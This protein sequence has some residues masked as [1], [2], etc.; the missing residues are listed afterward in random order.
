ML[1]LKKYKNILTII[2]VSLVS[3][4]ILY[5]PFLL[6]LKSVLGLVIHNSSFDYIYRNFDGVLYIVPAKTWYAPKLISA[7]R[8]EV[9]LPAEYYA[10]HL[11]VYPFFIWLFSSV[12]G[13]LKSMI[14][15][16]LLFTVCLALLFYYIVRYFKLSQNAFVLSLV[17]L[18]LPRFLVVRSVGAP[19]SM[20]MF[21]ILAS[22]LFFEKKNYLL[23]GVFGA[24]AS[25]TKTPGILLF[26]AYCFV[27]LEN[28]LKHRKFS[29]KSLWIL[30]VPVGLLGVFTLYAV[31]YGNFFAYIKTGGL[32]P[33]VY[34][35]SVFNYQAQWVGTAWLE[36]NLFYFFMYILAVIFL[37]DSKYRSFFY[38]SLIFLTATTFVRHMDIARYALPLWPFALIA[39]E[40][41]FTSKKVILAL[42]FLL[43]GIFLYAFNFLLYNVIPISDWRPFL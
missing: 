40:R 38:F 27:L 13:F 10:A 28:Y 37:K 30:L 29:A 41:F 25:A 24:L 21:F 31:Q 2:A 3:S 17:F 7:L 4:F 6:H 36:E 39:F 20:F 1:Y 12:I 14:M 19:E 9:P 26:I 32:V 22:V 42:Y 5:L 15:V 35:Y 33:L 8:L 16:N 23:A 18:F 11:P 43:P 34:P